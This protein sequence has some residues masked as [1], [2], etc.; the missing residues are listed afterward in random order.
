[1]NL[2]HSI[3]QT[4]MIFDL[5]DGEGAAAAPA[6]EE[7]GTPA[8]APKGGKN[9]M[10][11]IVY[12]KQPEA[13]KPAEETKPDTEALR[14]EYRELMSGKFKDLYAEETQRMINRRFADDTAMRNRMEQMQRAIDIVAQRYGVEDGNLDKVTNALLNDDRALKEGAE[15]AGMTVEQYKELE[16]LKRDNKALQAQQQNVLSQ[17]MRERQIQD[18]YRQSVELKQKFPGFDLETELQ[19]RNFVDAINKGVPLEQWYKAKYFDMFVGEAANMAAAQAQKATVDNIRAKGM[20]PAENGASASSAFTVK[21]DV[22]KLTKKDRAEI[23]RRVN[24]GESIRF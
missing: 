14:K 18:V 12:G 6:A 22:S 13:A 7:A 3:F 21:D 15:A 10:A 16:R 8:E 4:P 11:N 5:F 24:K 1:M 2:N 17:Q 19:D 9:A 23:A 20:R